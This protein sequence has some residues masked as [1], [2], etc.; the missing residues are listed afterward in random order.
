MS[1]AWFDRKCQAKK[2]A[3][4]VNTCTYKCKDKVDSNTLSEE[5]SADGVCNATLELGTF[6]CFMNTGAETPDSGARSLE[7]NV[8]TQSLPGKTDHLIN[9]SNNVSN[10]SYTKT[11]VNDSYPK[12]IDNKKKSREH[13]K[14]F[15][16]PKNDPEASPIVDSRSDQDN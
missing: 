6:P 12:N 3:L 9:Q 2:L 16:Y 15:I 4:N 10:V 7:N 14:C 5:Y 8:P 13:L 1:Y 11:N